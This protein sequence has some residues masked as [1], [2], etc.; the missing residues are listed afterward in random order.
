MLNPKTA[1]HPLPKGLKWRTEVHFHELHAV[2]R[3]CRLVLKIQRRGVL[4]V[5]KRSL[6]SVIVELP[7]LTEQTDFFNSP[8]IDQAEAIT[9]IRTNSEA[10]WL[11]TRVLLD[12]SNA[13]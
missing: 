5:F 11:Q 4:S 9:L 13:L 10:L 2:E 8:L 3:S 12:D 6:A 7:V 1:L